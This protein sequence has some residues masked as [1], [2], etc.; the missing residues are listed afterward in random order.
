MCHLKTITLVDLCRIGRHRQFQSSM[1][2]RMQLCQ[3]QAVGLPEQCGRDQ[4]RAWL[5]VGA[6]VSADLV[7]DLCVRVLCVKPRSHPL[8]PLR[9]FARLLRGSI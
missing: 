8:N 2:L 3:M 6:I 4:R 7:Q 9:G 1:L 5:A